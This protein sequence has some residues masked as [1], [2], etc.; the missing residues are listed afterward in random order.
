ML[1]WRESPV[2][3][4]EGRASERKSLKFSCTGRRPA[5]E[6]CDIQADGT[7]AAGRRRPPRHEPQW[8][9]REQF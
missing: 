8:Q 2:R 5:E 7:G 6:D 9:A 4:R 3:T 1:D